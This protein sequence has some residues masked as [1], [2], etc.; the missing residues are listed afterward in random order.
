MKRAVGGWDLGSIKL[1]LPIVH[2]NESTA[3]PMEGLP[4]AKEGGPSAMLL[5][6]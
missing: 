3:S 1:Q 5:L 2:M 6:H 4:M